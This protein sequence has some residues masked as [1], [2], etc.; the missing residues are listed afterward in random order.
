[1][2][3]FFS[4]DKYYSS[5]YYFRAHL[6]LAEFHQLCGRKLSRAMQNCQSLPLKDNNILSWRQP[7]GPVV[8]VS[9]VTLNRQARTSNAVCSDGF[10]HPPLPPTAPPPARAVHLLHSFFIQHHPLQRRP[11]IATFL[12]LGFDRLTVKPRTRWHGCQC[13]FYFFYFSFWRYLSVNLI[14]Q[15]FCTGGSNG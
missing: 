14:W 4:Q 15:C 5:Y 3:P 2:A 8:S 7:P 12:L 10:F 13:R 6:S 9:A 1:M 11:K